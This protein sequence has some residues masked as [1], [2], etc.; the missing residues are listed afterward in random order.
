LPKRVDAQLE[1]KYSELRRQ[2]TL[3]LVKEPMDEV[4]RCLRPIDTILQAW[5]LIPGGAMLYPRVKIGDLSVTSE[6]FLNH[7]STGYP[8]IYALMSQYEAQYNASVDKVEHIY[9]K[10]KSQLDNLKGKDVINWENGSTVWTMQAFSNEVDSQIRRGGPLQ[11][12]QV[13]S[14]SIRLSG[15]IIAKVHNSDDVN[16]VVNT[17]NS[18]LE[19]QLILGDL[20]DI[21]VGTQPLSEVYLRVGRRFSELKANAEAGVD[22]RGFCQGGVEAGYESDDLLRGPHDKA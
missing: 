20:E 12:C 1:G 21:W 9:S 3:T 17:M 11:K 8:E 7:L 18:L 6:Y 22:L 16:L 2:H 13:E 19:N 4:A 5:A 10:V 15:Y 14:F